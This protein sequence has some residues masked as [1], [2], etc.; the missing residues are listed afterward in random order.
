M[1]NRTGFGDS[2]PFEISTSHSPSL[3]IGLWLS[4]YDRRERR[5]GWKDLPEQNVVAPMVRTLAALFRLKKTIMQRIPTLLLTATLSIL[6]GCG[7]S[8]QYDPRFTVT[9]AT[10]D[11]I[12]K[13][14]TNTVILDFWA[15]W[16][17]PCRQMNP[18]FLAVADENP[19]VR[20]GKVNVDEEPALAEKHG[21]QGIPMFI[22]ISNGITVGSMIG[23]VDKKSFQAFVV[24]QKRQQ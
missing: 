11:G 9:S 2:F 21:V 14:A 5:H 23:S 16:C 13:G 15:S 4:Q 22:A 3:P 24:V 17:G 19:H 1:V 7:S 18:I 10:Y 20:F 8:T 12:T 6:C